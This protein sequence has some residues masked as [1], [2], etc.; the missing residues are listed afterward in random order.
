MLLLAGCG[1]GGAGSAL[2]SGD[3]QLTAGPLQITAKAGPKPLVTISGTTTNLV[4]VSNGSFTNVLANLPKSLGNTA[5]AFGMS[6]N[7]WVA[8]PSFTNLTELS[9]YPPITNTNPSMNG[10]G[11]ITY[12]QFINGSY[13]T[14]VMNG[15]GSGNHRLDAGVTEDETPTYTPD[16]GSILFSRNTQIYKMSASGTNITN[17][18]DGTAE[19]FQ[20][21]QSVNGL[22]AFVRLNNATLSDDIWVMNSDGTNKHVVLSNPGLYFAQP[23]FSPDGSK[24]VCV[25]GVYPPNGT[26]YLEEYVLATGQTAQLSSGVS[27]VSDVWPC[28]SPDGQHLLF[29]RNTSSASYVMEATQ[30]GF[31]ATPVY[32]APSGA[33]MNRVWWSP[34]FASKLYV[35]T[36]G[37]FGTACDGFVLAEHEDTITSFVAA[38]ASTG[39]VLNIAPDAQVPAVQRITPT[40]GT[41]KT[42]LY[43]NGFF[44]APTTVSTGTAKQVVVTFDSLG[45]VSFVI[46]VTKM[47]SGPVISG[48][49]GIF[50]AKGHNLAPNGASSVAIGTNGK[51]TSMKLL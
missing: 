22:I 23:N 21:V 48:A 17:L 44:T 2:S 7:V 42:V 26:Q 28:F 37:T 29:G 1:G 39:G 40:S 51:I 12:D 25:T 10:L 43:A 14:F 3:Q 31:N 41:V 34:Y 30:D 35:G 36:G 4:A 27:N 6:G 33:V 8:D 24:I 46:P 38:V 11:R 50:D 49:L 15:D 20:P 13:L 5:I 45:H 19:D 18:D 32:T 9:T 47:G 16:N